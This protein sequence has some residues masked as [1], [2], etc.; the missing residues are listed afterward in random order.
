MVRG[1]GLLVV[2][3]LG[4]ACAGLP[5]A[6]EGAPPVAPITAGPGG[7]GPESASGLA[8]ST[9]DPLETVKRLYA[10]YEAGAAKPELIPL[11]TREAR[12]AWDRAAAKASEG[13]GA[14]P[15]FQHDLVV[16]AQ[17]FR[18]SGLDVSAGKGSGLRQAVVASFDN[19]GRRTVVRYDLRREDGAWR[20]DDLVPLEPAGLSMRDLVA[21]TLRQ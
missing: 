3:G 21:E 20:I 5:V 4:L 10:Q 11:L 8:P 15:L 13:E 17:D 1:A 18:I 6:Q 16:Q 19:Q 12:D 14:A 9:T 2:L 7:A